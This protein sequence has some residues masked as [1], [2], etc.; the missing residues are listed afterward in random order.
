[1]AILLAVGGG[2]DRAEGDHGCRLGS[3]LEVKVINVWRCG[4]A[5]RGHVEDVANHAWSN[6][7]IQ[8]G[9]RIV[10]HDG[11]PFED[12]RDEVDATRVKI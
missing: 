5:R 1:M 7:T 9:S 6:R 2:D 4:H 8:S 11:L 10:R 3:R 12:G